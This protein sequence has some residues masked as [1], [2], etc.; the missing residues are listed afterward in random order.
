MTKETILYLIKMYAAMYNVSPSLAVSVAKVE[1]NLNQYALGSLGEV[2]L[3]QIRPEYVEAFTT[4]DLYNVHFNIIIGVKMLRDAKRNCPNQRELTW[5]TC[6]NAGL[7][8]ASKI[9]DPYN[10]G[11]VKKVRKEYY[12]KN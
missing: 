4:K 3:F 7:N 5:L 1:S 11:Y 8:G 12:G 6:Y 2:G 9:K 10:F